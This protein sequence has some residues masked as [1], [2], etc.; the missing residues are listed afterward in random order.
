MGG[1]M[2]RMAEK[3]AHPALL[4]EGAARL[5]LTAGRQVRIE[6]YRCL[7]SF[8]EETLE[9]GCGKQTLRVH[10]QGLRICSMDRL[11]ILLDGAIFSVEVENA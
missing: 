2:D 9:I 7:L 5:T 8:S 1:V 10:G 6:N 3:L 11:E 4:P